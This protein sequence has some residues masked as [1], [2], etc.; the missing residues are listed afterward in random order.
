MAE[1]QQ[2]GRGGGS[3]SK[4]SSLKHRMKENEVHDSLNTERLTALAKDELRYEGFKVPASP[5]SSGTSSPVMKPG[6]T[7]MADEWEIPFEQ[8]SLAKIL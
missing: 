7:A 2:L 6:D 4:P 5:F 1:L 8:V 3:T